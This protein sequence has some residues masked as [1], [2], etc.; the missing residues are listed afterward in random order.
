MRQYSTVKVKLYWNKTETDL[1]KLLTDT[2]TVTD[3]FVDGRRRQSHPRFRSRWV[4]TL[5]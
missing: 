1:Q 2:E 4:S 3:L 5:K